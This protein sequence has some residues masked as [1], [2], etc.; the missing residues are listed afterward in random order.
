M[1]QSPKTTG[2]L[3][4]I[5]ARPPA[6]KSLFSKHYLQ[7]RLPEHAEWHE[8]PLPAFEELRA[9]WVK[10]KTFGAHWNEAQTEDELINPALEALGWTFTVQTKS[11]KR[12]SVARPDY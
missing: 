10:A 9:L 5:P 3:D 1:P 4:P 6:G 12:G 2:S 8:D 11:Q 7:Q